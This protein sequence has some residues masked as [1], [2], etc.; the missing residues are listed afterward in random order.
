MLRTPQRDSKGPHTMTRTWPFFA[1]RTLV[2]VVV[3][4]A[5][6]APVKVHGAEADQAGSLREIVVEAARQLL[7]LVNKQPVS[8]GEFTA[9]GKRNLNSGPELV[10]L[11]KEELSRLK[12]V[13]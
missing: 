9:T 6:A 5:L 12:A 7:D 13:V 10:A 3:G 2:M 8:I 4:F 11:L 1:T